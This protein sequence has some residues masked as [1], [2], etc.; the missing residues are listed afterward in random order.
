MP[1][2]SRPHAFDWDD[3]RLALAIVESGTLS[4]AAASLHLSHPTLS[5]RLQLMEQRLG[6]RLFE[7]TPGGLQPTQAGEEVKALA[8]RW[9]DEAAELER[10]VSG[11]DD[12]QDGPVRLTAPDAVSEYLLPGVLAAVCR[13]QVGLQLELKVSNEVVSLARR[14]ADIALRVTRSPQEN[15]R[16]REVGTVAMAVYAPRQLT[17]AGD[18]PASPGRLP[19]VG[20]DAGLACSAP[21]SWLAR[22]VAPDDVRF[23]ANT[24]LGAAQAARAGI[25][26]AVLPC[27]VGGAIAEL[28]R[29]GPPLDELAQPLWLLMHEDVAR[30][31]RMR[32]ASAAL[33]EEI[34]LS[35]RLM[36][37]L[38]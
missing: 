9:R 4:G 31:P 23:R 38:D 6:T 21:G 11:R 32:R 8:L 19:W 33:A 13:T 17:P 28:V 26:C 27:F 1:T 22:N 35:S 30:V 37:G 25:G 10:R 16:G 18:A 5:R 20:F 24:L 34:A 2:M 15:L 14:E 3:L 7:R 12:G 29:V 36:S